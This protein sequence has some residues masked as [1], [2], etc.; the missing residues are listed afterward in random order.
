M[1]PKVFISYSHDTP[2]HKAWVL[3]FAEALREQGV[4]AV[5]D[6]WDLKLGQ[7]VVAFM[8]HGIAE[9]DRVIMIC[10]DTYVLKAEAGLGGV[11]YERLIVT[12]EVSA[13][14]DTNKFI[15]VI[16]NHEQGGRLVPIFLGPRLYLDFRNDD[17]YGSLIEELA[18]ELH[19]IYA[20]KKPPLGAPS[21][22]V[23]MAVSSG[24][25]G[26]AAPVPKVHSLDG[27]WFKAEADKADA[28]LARRGLTGSMEVRSAVSLTMNAGQAELLAA[29]QGSEIRTFGWPIGINLTSQDKWSAKPYTDGIRTEVDIP[30]EESKTGT[31][32][33]DYWAVSTAGDFYTSMKLFE[34]DRDQDAIF[35]NTRI[36]RVAETFM[37][38]NGLY[39]RLGAAPETEITARFR[40]RGLTNR[41][42]KSAGP[43]RWVSPR[44]SAEGV[45]VAEVKAKLSEIGDALPELV[46]RV[47]APMFTLF[48]FMKFENT[49][50]EDIVTRFQRGE[51]S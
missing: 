45:S 36:I 7:D 6:Q 28:G 4:D 32:S 23:A 2:D 46:S 48:D 19:G 29:V 10:S 40:H 9:A 24:G 35:F 33:Y 43:T 17:Q 51:A 16:R 38:L 39:T 47:C 14:I 1:A 21:F 8:Q 34:D 12:A 11:G 27:D 44:K 13:N 41:V 18:R 49:V 42:L 25:T 37:F 15:P 5:L 3:T 30:L 26:G 22:A 50:Y 20:V 31:S